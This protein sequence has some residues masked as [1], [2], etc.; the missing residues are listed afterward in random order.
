MIIET[1]PSPWDDQGKQMRQHVS[2]VPNSA[3][4]GLSTQD[5]G[6]WTIGATAHA[7]PSPGSDTWQTLNK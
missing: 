1:A 3:R 7:V 4:G 6:V 5:T 2:K